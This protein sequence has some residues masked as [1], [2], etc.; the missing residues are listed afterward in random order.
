MG[1]RGGHRRRRRHEEATEHPTS[2]NTPRPPPPSRPLG[3]GGGAWRGRGV[4][5]GVVGLFFL[6][7][8]VGEVDERRQE[9]ATRP[10]SLDVD[11]NVKWASSCESVISSGKWPENV[12]DSDE[13]YLF[14]GFLPT[15][16]GDR[17]E[18]LGI[19]IPGAFTYS[20][21]RVNEKGVLPEGYKLKFEFY[22]TRGEEVMGSSIMVD[23]LCRNVSA[24]FGPE[25]TCFVEGT[26]A[27]GHNLPMLSYGCTNE[28]ASK[29]KTFVRTNPSEIYII[30]TAV[31]AMKHNNWTRFSVIYERDQESTKDTLVREAESSNMTVNHVIAYDE[32]RLYL[33]LDATKNETRIYVYVG[34]RT[35][36][37]KLLNV[38]AMTGMFP[39]GKGS[40]E[41]LLLY[42]ENEEYNSD[43]WLH[44]IWGNTAT[45]QKNSCRA[46]DLLP[47]Y[48]AFM[49]VANRKPE[50]SEFSQ[51]VREYNKRAP[52]CLGHSKSDEYGNRHIPYLPSAHLYD[53]VQLYARVVAELYEEL[54]SQGQNVSVP[55]IARNGTLIKDRL[56]NITYES[57]LGFNMTMNINATSEGKYSVYLFSECPSANTFNCSLCLHK[58]S[59][60]HSEN[61]SLDATA[62][63]LDILDEPYCGYDGH[64]CDTGQQ[65]QKQIAWVLGSILILCLFISTILYRNWKYEQEIVGLQWRINQM[66]LTMSNN[67]VSAGSRQSLVSAVSFDLHGLWYQNL[68]KYKGAVVCVKMIPLNQKRPE[69]SRNTMKEMRNM[70]EMKQDNVCAFIGAYVEHN[71]TNTGGER[72]KVA[73][74]SEYCPRGSLLDILA[75]EDIKLD[76]LF[77]SSLVHDLLRGMIFL[78]S[79]FGPHGNLKSS[80]CVVNSRW[81]LQITDYGLH[82]LR[83]ETLNQLERD[84]QVQF[85]RQMLWRAP[86]L[87]RKGIDAPGT[88]EGDVYSFGI[89]FHEIIGR[90]GPYGIYDIVGND[91]ATDIIR[92]L[93]AGSTEAGSPY[94][95]NMNKIVDM[96]FG[97]DSAVRTS[98][99]SSWSESLTERPTF[100]TLKLKLKGM[101][102]K[103]KRG[104]LMDHMMQMME[105]YSK[106][107]EDLVA[108]RTQAL[109]DEERMTKD[110][111]HRM[112]PSS[113]ASSLLQGIAVEPHGFDAV[114]IYF[115]D[116]VGFTSL[117]AESTPYEVVTF[118]NDLYTLFDKI[119]RGYDVYKVETI[120]DAYMVVSGLPHPNNGRHAGEIASMA[121][122]LLDGVRHKFVIHHRP[123]KK[124]LLRIGLHTGPV[125]A[126]VVGLTM[127]RYCLFGD[128]VNTASRME[129]NG[130]PL[131][132]HISQRCRDALE[133]LGGYLTEKRGLVPMKGKGEVLTYWLNG[134]TKEAIQRR[135]VLPVAPVCSLEGPLGLLQLVSESVPPLLQVG[136]TEGGELRKRSPRLSSLGNRT[137]SVPRSMEDAGDQNGVP[138][139]VLEDTP[140]RD[141]PRSEIF[142]RRRL[143]SNFRTSSIDNTP[144][145]SLL[146]PPTTNTPERESTPDSIP[147]SISLDGLNQS[148]LR[149]EVPALQTIT[150]ATSPSSSEPTLPMEDKRGVNFCPSARTGGASVPTQGNGEREP[151]LCGEEG[152]ETWEEE[153]RG[154][155]G[156]G[157]P[158]PSSPEAKSNSL[159]AWFSG[160]F[161]HPK[162]PPGIASKF[163]LNGLRRENVV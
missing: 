74:V 58:I 32:E 122:E 89:I 70:R 67:H 135:E 3:W 98:M 119:I 116:I 36:V 24:V 55:E 71:K 114:T 34:H 101:K 35:Y 126:G 156:D 54:K 109:R 144:R 152:E 48:K 21:E 43:D 46:E 22:D 108:T 27:E 77:I 45:K 66:D 102:D 53:S 84:D 113:V 91:D 150:A 50:F 136:H 110:L 82:D 90:Q 41:Y 99:Q 146:C 151:M 78:H 149:L 148:G 42:I 52:F 1:M 18:R 4:L 79:H 26:I 121:L 111:L 128:T 94:R 163:T 5:W 15:R 68:A 95:P 153:E 28:I 25:H 81:V 92:K 142:R 75:M 97:S 159:K 96:P 105:Q 44:Y 155:R 12:S 20:A 72:T 117:S 132:I 157:S 93:K 131:R 17:M 147:Q 31:A 140:M 29:F 137:S 154:T 11:H 83:C 125:I 16:Q 7:C 8:V 127:P 88:K 60:Y 130:E 124:L 14:V 38:M 85:H 129:S 69:L 133:G 9:L 6:S 33:I 106:N 65:Y 139:G 39:A 47:F 57:I 51:R 37:E 13:K 120:G 112:L 162:P 80:N 107:L 87:L 161:R 104:N 141:S 138:G 143:S 100:R 2:P 134:A 158:I 30:R 160:F 115:S 145:G 73:L 63:R 10:T 103:G 19:K 40:K 86:E 59:D 123:K 76:C 56:R 23:L 64:K 62:V 118:L 49:V 61:R